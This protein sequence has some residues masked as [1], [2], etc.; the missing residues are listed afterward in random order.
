M[1]RDKGSLSVLFFFTFIY[2]VGAGMCT[3]KCL[4]V[5]VCTLRSGQRRTGGNWLSLFPSSGLA[6]VTLP[7]GHVTCPAVALHLDS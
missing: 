3:H 4:S 7:V 2:S 6:T 5:I 1:I